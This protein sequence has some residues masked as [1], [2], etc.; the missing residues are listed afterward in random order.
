MMPIEKSYLDV[1]NSHDFNYPFLNLP[2]HCR[3]QR[4]PGTPTDSFSSLSKGGRIQVSACG[5]SIDRRRQDFD[6]TGRR[7]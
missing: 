2:D 4:N 5:E 3:F 1:E 7:A 6:V